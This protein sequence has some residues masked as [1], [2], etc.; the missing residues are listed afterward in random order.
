MQEDHGVFGGAG[1]M[2]RTAGAHRRWCRPAD[3]WGKTAQPM[4]VARAVMTRAFVGEEAR[5]AA[6]R[7]KSLGLDSFCPLVIWRFPSLV[8]GQG[9]SQA[10]RLSE[11]HKTNIVICHIST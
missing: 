11:L 10:I 3:A 8:P 6:G 2:S 4:T 7:M 1:P 9:Q 5:H